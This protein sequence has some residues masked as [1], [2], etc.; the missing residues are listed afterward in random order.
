MAIYGLPERG[1]VRGD[2]WQRMEA[3]MVFMQQVRGTILKHQDGKLKK[4][5]QEEYHNVHENC[6]E[7]QARKHFHFHFCSHLLNNGPS[8]CDRVF[9]ATTISETQIR[10]IWS[11]VLKLGYTFPCSHTPAYWIFKLYII[12][13]LKY[14]L[15]HLYNI[16]LVGTP[17][18]PRDHKSFHMPTLE[19]KQ[20]PQWW[21]VSC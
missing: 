7:I 11:I 1:H 9:D 19:I 3:G 15:Q 20:R 16:S 13:G 5:R 6:K 2:K 18:W 14:K 4:K 17:V 12:L 10:D 8:T 21:E